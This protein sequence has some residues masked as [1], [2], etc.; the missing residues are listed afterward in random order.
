MHEV[1]GKKW[2]MKFNIQ[3]QWLWDSYLGYKQY[4]LDYEDYE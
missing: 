1:D 2:I 4:N 3:L